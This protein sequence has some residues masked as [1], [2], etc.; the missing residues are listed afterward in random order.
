MLMCSSIRL[1]MD[2]QGKTWAKSRALKQGYPNACTTPA[3][4]TQKE[5]E[6]QKDKSS[7]VGRYSPSLLLV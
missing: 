3:R 6:E 2:K 4:L 7:G 1:S 5:E